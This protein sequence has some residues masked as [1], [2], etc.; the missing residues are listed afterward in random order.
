MPNLN[1]TD[2]AG[3]VGAFDILADGFKPR[4]TA[5]N[6]NASSEKYLYIAMADL[7]GNGTL[8]PIYGR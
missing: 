1:D 5:A 7:G 6:T 3:Q 8:P 2:T 4:D